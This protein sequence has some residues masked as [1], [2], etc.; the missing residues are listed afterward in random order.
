MGQEWGFWLDPVLGEAKAERAMCSREPSWYYPG[1]TT[2]G[3]PV[4]LVHVRLH[5]AAWHG[6][7]KGGMG[8]KRAVRNSP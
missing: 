4:I 6:L 1:S 7:A 5:G 8:S 2:L 3:T